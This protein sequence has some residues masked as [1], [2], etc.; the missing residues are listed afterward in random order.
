MFT[1]HTNLLLLT[2][3]SLSPMPVLADVIINDVTQLNPISMAAVVAP[4]TVQ[5]V[6]DAVKNT[7]GPISIGGGRYSMGGQTAVEHGTQI[8][9]RQ[10]NHVVNFSP[11]QKEITVQAGMTWRQVQEAIDPAG[12]AVDIMQTY[13]NFTVG[14]ALSVNCHGRYVGRGPLVLSVKSIRVVLADGSLVNA[15]PTE[16]SDIFYGAIGGYG[17][18]GVIVEATLN[19]AD[20]VKVER[21]SVLMPLSDYPAW[22]ASHVGNNPDVIFHNADIYP[23]S[24]NTVRATSYVKTDKPVTVKDHLIPLNKS[25]LKDRLAFDVI[26]EWPFGK[27]IRQHVL[28]PLLFS[29]DTV[30]WRNYEASYRVEEL[31]PASRKNSS[32]VLQEYFVPEVNFSQFVAGMSQVLNDNHVNAINVSIRHAK[33]DPGTLMAWARKDVFAFVLYYKQGTSEDDRKAVG[34]W[35]RQMID[36]VIAAGGSYYL[37]YQPAATVEQFHAAY[38]NADR[39]FALK[40][41]LDPTDKFRNTLWDAYYVPQ[42]QPQP[43][44]QSQAGKGSAPVVGNDMPVSAAAAASPGN[45]INAA[46]IEIATVPAS[47]AAAASEKPVPAVVASV[48]TSTDSAAP[49]SSNKSVTAPDPMAASLEAEARKIP[50]YVRD[51]G[52]TYLTLPEWF[53]VY[54]PEEYAQYLKTHSNNSGFPYFSSIGQTWGNYYD[55]AHIDNQHG[56]PVNWGYHLMVATIC[57]SYTVELAIKGS[58]EN[59]V[60]RLTEWTAGGKRTPED[61]YAAGVAQDYVDFVRIYPWYEY[62]FMHSLH[63][64]WTLH[65]PDSANRTRRWERR[66]FLSTGYLIKAGYGGV[67][68]LATKAIYGDADSEMFLLTSPI[69]PGQFQPVKGVRTYREYSDGSRLLI[70]PRYEEFRDAIIGLSRD[71]IGFREIA[72]NKQILMTLITPDSWKY[73]GEG[74]QSLFERPILTQPGYKR[75]ALNVQV[76]ALE[77]VVHKLDGQGLTIEHIYDY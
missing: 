52:Q 58:Y 30:E 33:Q 42:P 18:I 8:D 3:L 49:A 50:G 28:D 4:T 37:P 21:Q 76:P 44:A 35:T 43:Q 77:G 48:S 51:E 56:Y 31:E 26:S 16:H 54:N 74:A 9:M 27:A 47:T 12:L 59:S 34:S 65:D 39:F 19:L 55:V 60:G 10:L 15:S 13:D 68:K 2:I 11:E 7:P 1:R 14:G 75:V 41:Q 63:G 69:G 6:V 57:S 46:N 64:L 25:Y 67:I 61:D 53:L 38:P 32:Y 70:L 17:G 5:Q 72:G 40:R 36:Q 24:Y 45:T 20:N 22:F 29:G 73:S 66:A 71:N 62:S 23:N